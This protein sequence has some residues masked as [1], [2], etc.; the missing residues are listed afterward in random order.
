STRHRFGWPSNWMAGST[1]NRMRASMTKRA[2]VGLHH[3]ASRCCATRT[4]MCLDGLTMCW[5]TSCELSHA[6][7]RIPPPLRG[8]PLR[9]EGGERAR[10]IVLVFPLRL[11]RGI[12]GDGFSDVAARAGLPHEH[13]C[14]AEH[15]H[16]RRIFFPVARVPAHLRGA[17]HAFGVRHQDGDAARCGGETRHAIGRTVGVVRERFG[18]LAAVVHKA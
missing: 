15:A 8:D 12:E 9:S 16:P 13:A 14:V 1:T 18:R 11:R 5:M 6:C 7:K 10:C 17:E 2:A 4:W 3:A